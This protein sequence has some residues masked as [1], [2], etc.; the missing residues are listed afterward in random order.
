MTNYDDVARRWR[1]RALGVTDKPAL[2]GN[3]R[4]LDRGDAI[5]SYGTHFEIAR[6]IRD[7]KGQPSHWLVNGDTSS[8]TTSRH[9]AVVRRVIARGRM[10]LPSVTIP[11]SVLSAASI[12]LDSVE[13][14][15]VTPDRWETVTTVRDEFPPEAAWEYET[16]AI[17]G[18]GVWVRE[19]DGL[20]I[21]DRWDSKRPDEPRLRY[22]SESW[23]D[24]WERVRKWEAEW[25]RYPRVYKKTGRK[26][27]RN[28]RGWLTWE[29]R[30]DGEGGIEYVNMRERHWLGESLVKGRVSYRGRVKCR[31]CEGAGEVAPYSEPFADDQGHGPLTWRQDR[32]MPDDYAE[33]VASGQTIGRHR[34]VA[35]TRLTTQCPDCGGSRWQNAWK[36]RTAYFLSGFDANE[37]RPSYFFS[38]CPPKARPTTVAEAYAS[39]KP[40][41]VRLAEEMGRSV[42]RQGDIFSIAMPDLTLREL[43]AQGGALEKRRPL[44]STNHT[45]TEVVRVGRLTYA[46]GMMRHE[47][48]GRRPD[49]ARIRLGDG[50]TWHLIVKNTV[51]VN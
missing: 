50:K 49:H 39:L 17:P 43:K 36:T 12:A 15:Q 3:G 19:R 10:V 41:S 23:D 32:W 24:F 6:L 14:V 31:T 25:T 16:E 37:A 46:R 4:M 11:Y 44:L 35:A 21:E 51:P 28:K 2:K 27:I 33:R 5:Y 7:R 26:S 48:E 40:E 42:E 1:D 9:Q 13:I 18:T 8:P 47:P 30:D 20:V 45:A 29:M 22:G 34:T 38:E